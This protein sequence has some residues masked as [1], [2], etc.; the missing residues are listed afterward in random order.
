MKIDKRLYFLH[1]PKT[2]GMS[3]MVNFGQFLTNNDIAKYPPSSP[4]HSDVSNEYAFIQGHLGRYPIE[5]VDNLS[6]A[7][8]IRNP[9]DRA[10]SYFLYIYDN[11]LKDKKEY[12]E[13]EKFE[14]K[15]KYHLFEDIEYISHRNIQSKF[16]CSKPLE[17]RYKDFPLNLDILRKNKSKNWGLQ[18]I[19]INFDL[20]KSYIDSFDIINTTDNLLIFIENLVKWFNENYSDIT[21]NNKINYN[22]IVNQSK[23]NINNEI[24]TTE[25]LKPFLSDEDIAKF[26]ELNSIDFDL[27]EYVYKKENN[28]GS[29][30]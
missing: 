1:I 17:N 10:I 18:E 24:Y 2:G 3:V 16:I 13:I 15:L 9:L 5:K 4:P 11:V 7:T 21:F 27:Y 28:N 19:E 20:V 12:L 23:V 25:K 26:L 30:K 6:L 29:K 8:I 14:D 22:L